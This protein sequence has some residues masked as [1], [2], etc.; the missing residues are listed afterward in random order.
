MLSL[1]FTQVLIFSLVAAMVANVFVV[2]IQYYVERNKLSL[3]IAAYW[4]SIIGGFLSFSPSSRENIWVLMGMGAGMT[5]SQGILG[6]VFAKVLQVEINFRIPIITYLLG[7]LTSAILFFFE[8]DFVWATFPLLVGSTVPFPYFS[9]MAIKQKK[10]PLTVV[11]KMFFVTGLTIAFH[12]LDWGYCRVRPE[13]FAVGIVV[14]YIQ[15]QMLAVLFPMMINENNLLAKNQKLEELAQGRAEELAQ[16]E[17]QLWESNRLASLG[18]MAAG[19]AHEI[20]NP[21]L[22]IQLQAETLAAS[23]QKGGLVTADVLRA[24]K[25]ISEIVQ[26]IS[27]ITNGLLNLARKPKLLDLPKCEVDQV[28][29]ETVAVCQQRLRNLDIKFKYTCD[30]LPI[31]AAISSGELNQVLLN[32]LNNSVDAIEHLTERSI[33]IKVLRNQESIE[34]SVIDSGKIAPELKNKVLDPFFTTK[35]LGKGTGLGLSIS[36]SIVDSHG[37]K[38]SLDFAHPTTKFVVALKATLPS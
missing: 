9:A 20:N 22:I 15:L 4:F 13:F 24:T 27:K 6:S 33:E 30:E 2:F 3:W 12:S 16:A 1:Q 23:V 32:L 8:V 21:I 19:V 36:R 7:S 18:Q 35:P 38:L 29:N 31:W 26:R 17:R 28:I 10:L 25:K 11:Q 14:A 37:G 34:L 5:F